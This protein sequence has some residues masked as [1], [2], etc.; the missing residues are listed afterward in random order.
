MSLKPKLNQVAN[1]IGL[2]SFQALGGR[3]EARARHRGRHGVPIQPLRE[4]I[5][6][7][8]QALPGEQFN[9]AIEISKFC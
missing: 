9:C 7:H 2:G 4:D 1:P 5:G 3:V 8:P 6:R